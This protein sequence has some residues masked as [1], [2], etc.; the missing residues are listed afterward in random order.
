M[1]FLKLAQE[2]PPSYYYDVGISLGIPYAQLRAILSENLNNFKN[3]LMDVFMKWNVKHQPS[4]L[5]TRQ[6]LADK[7]QEIGLKGLSD[8][9]LNESPFLNYSTGKQITILATPE[10]IE[11]HA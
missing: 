4:Y 10:D 7:L 5:N 3:A 2:I 9:L 1:E 8:R 6:L 11:N